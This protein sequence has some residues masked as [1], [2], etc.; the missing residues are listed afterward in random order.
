YGN[1]TETKVFQVD[2]DLPGSI[3]AF[4]PNDRMGEQGGLRSPSFPKSRAKRV[5]AAFA[6]VIHAYG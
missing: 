6:V 5:R 3:L 2:L 4:L 1:S